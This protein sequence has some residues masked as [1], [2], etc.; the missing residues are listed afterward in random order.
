MTTAEDCRRKAGQ[1]LSAAQA[2][3]DPKTSASMRRVS[4]LWT[5]LGRQIEA[6][7]PPAADFET[8][9]K[10]PAGYGHAAKLRQT[11]ADSLQVADVLRKR[12]RLSG[13]PL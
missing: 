8:P 13:E 1:W 4:D 5:L 12:L 3:D 7:V 11:D 6:F 10:S 9:V 2:A